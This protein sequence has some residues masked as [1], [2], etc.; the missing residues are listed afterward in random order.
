MRIGQHHDRGVDHTVNLEHE[1]WTVRVV[2]ADRRPLGELADRVPGLPFELDLGGFTRLDDLPGSFPL[3][4]GN[5]AGAG[6]TEQPDFEVAF[7]RVLDLPLPRG[8]LLG[9]KLSELISERALDLDP[10]LRSLCLD[11]GRQIQVGLE[12]VPY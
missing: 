1:F 5:G 4:L 7:A 10:R 2:G 8:R 12:P 9:G 3:E 11:A 6:G